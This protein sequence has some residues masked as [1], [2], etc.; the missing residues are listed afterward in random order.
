VIESPSLGDRAVALSAE[1]VLQASLVQTQQWMN[2]VETGQPTADPPT[3]MGLGRIGVDGPGF[4]VFEDHGRCTLAR[5]AVLELRPDGYIVDDRGAL[6]LGYP[7][8]PVGNPTPLHV[9]GEDKALAGVEVD[10]G[11]QISLAG[12]PLRAPRDRQPVIV[13]R[14]ALAL[15]SYPQ[16]DFG[17]T[18]R[19]APAALGVRPRFFAA[20]AVH[21]G[22]IQHN[23]PVLNP[24]ALRDTIRALWAASGRGEIE[25]AV[26]ASA[27]ALERTALNLVR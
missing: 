25:V 7:G 13:G 9:P 10:D 8:A 3:P 27:D 4:L 12:R 11:G 18:P 21:V 1:S 15:P 14:I 22:R 17:Q 2:L 24:G 23:P 5:E 19:V 16:V 20:G 6:L 26:A